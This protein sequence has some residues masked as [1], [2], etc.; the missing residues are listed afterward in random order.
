MRP[1]FEAKE[2]GVAITLPAPIP[3][4]II[5]G[6]LGAGKTTLLNHILSTNHGVRA[7]VLVNDFG[8]INI[9]AKLVV[10]VEGDTIK[11]ENGCVCCNIRDDLVAACLNLLQSD[12]PPEMLLIE[13]SGVSDPAQVANTFGSSDFAG[14]FTV[15]TVLTLA[16]A[17]QLPRLSGDMVALATTQIKVADFVVLNKVDLVTPS[18]LEDVTTLIRSVSPKV[19]IL[20]T[21]QGRVPLALVLDPLN[22]HSAAAEEL[23]S[24]AKHGH[25]GHDHD[26]APHHDKTFDTWHWRCDQKLSL[27]KLR[28]VL[29]NLPDTIYRAK[30]L[31]YTEELPVFRIVLQLV[32]TRYDLSETD[33]WGAEQPGSEVVMITQRGG[34]DHAA[35]EAAFQ[36]CIG[37]G[38]DSDS[39]VLR[40]V[41]K[42]APQYLDETSEP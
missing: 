20:E 15:N 25:E 35:L 9:D 22:S 38:D 11:L 30:G 23:Q 21:T 6:F 29:D 26:H 19:R 39:P 34:L 18:Q 32:G 10:G 36:G 42:L 33:G 13:T 28:A 4:T 24:S 41:K 27:P 16:D 2:E 37:T 40:L 8:A 17:E 31:F 3:V 7:G 1:V 5:A 12:A 14:L